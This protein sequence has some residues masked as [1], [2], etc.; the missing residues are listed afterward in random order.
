MSQ[1]PFSI[2]F[3]RINEKIIE[4]EQEIKPIFEDFDSE[5]T[6]N[7]IYILTGP[8]GFGK[9]VTLGHIIDVYKDKKDWVV[10]RLSQSDNMLEQMASLL[11]EN[12]LSKLKSLKIEF[13]FSFQ[14]F[15]FC[16]KGEKPISSI[17]VY[18]NNLLEY[19]KKKGVH[20]LV[21]I[22]DVAKNKGMLDFIRVYQGF[23]ID[24]YDVRLLI[25]GLA[26]N[27]S[28]LETD[29]SLTFLFRAPKIQLSPLS[30]QAIAISYQNTFDISESES[31]R[32]AKTTKG[33]ALAYQ[34]LGD[35]LYKS[36]EKNLNSKV[37][38]EFDL[39]LSEWSYEIIW[40]ELTIKEQQILSI[41]ADGFSSNKDLMEKLSDTS[42][43]NLA[44]YKKKLAQEGLINVLVRGKCT[45]T[46]PRFAEF[47]HMRKLLIDD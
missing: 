17:H 14:G 12:G 25:T 32:L 43:G 41:I 27:V 35:I 39:K 22:D 26:K 15:S 29:R 46:L 11:Y 18:L 28:K 30:I 4:R 7:T 9:T 8:R 36:I 2:S 44:I 47:I 31:L 16:V 33:Y 42:K 40:S 1:N 6:R 45:F 5:P 21:A 34:I 23:L 3:G 37:L 24:H 38:K 20:A 13:S 19:F 10:A